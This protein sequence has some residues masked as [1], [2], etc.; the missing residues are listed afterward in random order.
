[1][2]E[3]S[4]CGHNKKAKEGAERVAGIIHMWQRESRERGGGSNFSRWSW[5]RGDFL[6]KVFIIKKKKI[7]FH[8]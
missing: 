6:I 5:R 7:N 4:P 2:S 8:F 1:M 3:G